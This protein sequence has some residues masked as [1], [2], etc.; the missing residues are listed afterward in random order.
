MAKSRRSARRHAPVA[1]AT[2]AP[3]RDAA[4]PGGLDWHHVALAVVLLATTAIRLHLLAVPFER[5]EGEY[6]YIGRLLLEGG[7]PYRDAYSMK[8]PGTSAM[9]ALILAVFGGSPA[10]VHAG[11]LV[12]SGIT[13][14]CWYL[15]I[16]RLFTPMIGLVTASVYG[17]LAV[18]L[19][20][21]GFA[22]H[23][24]QFIAL[25]LSL[26]VLCYAWFDDHERWWDAALAGT[27]AGLAFVMK[28]QAAFFVLFIWLMVAARSTLGLRPV[29]WRR[30]ALRTAA[31]VAGSLVPYL[32]LLAIVWSTGVFRQF[33]LWTVDYAAAYEATPWAP[34]VRAGDRWP[35]VL[36]LFSSSFAPMFAEYPALWLLAGVGAGA[37]WIGPFTLRQRLFATL[38]G[39]SAVASASAGLYFRPHYFVVLAPVVGLLSAIA[40]H[41]ATLRLGHLIRHPAVALVPFAVVLVSAAVAI[42]GRTGY[43]VVD[44][45]GAI[46]QQVYAGNPFVEASAIGQYIGD[47]TTEGDTVAVLGSEP[48]ILVHARRRSATGYL[49]VYPLFEQ[50]PHNVAMQRQMIAEIE[51]ARP[52]FV[53][54]VNVPSSWLVMPGSPTELL[55][56]SSSYLGAHYD[57]V[58][59]VDVPPDGGPAKR[60]V[61]TSAR[62]AAPASSLPT[63]H[64]ARAV[65]CR[66]SR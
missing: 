11:L 65:P 62:T 28:Q 55:Q 19:P 42:G 30:A 32:I 48:E 6:T 39:L 12:V 22:A 31:S 16:R 41:V 14:V 46:S 21:L 49:Y 18:S 47:H 29:A 61:V 4:R 60:D 13:I 53:V 57:A 10:G 26:A 56:W 45:P 54:Y 24:T 52:R 66:S 63:R 59:L 40:L 9:Y 15:A 64:S 8:L 34:L 7:L 51:S 35:V 1:V 36:D 23:A 25:F 43:Y 27:M 33:W 37:V 2:G 5:D 50:Q 38:F 20:F 58:G 44:D 3:A 17:L